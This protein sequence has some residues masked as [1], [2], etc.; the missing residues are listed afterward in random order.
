[1]PHARSTD[2]LQLGLSVG[3]NRDLDLGSSLIQ[4]V[5]QEVDAPSLE[6]HHGLSMPVPVH[7]GLEWEDDPAGN[8]NSHDGITV[9]R[10]MVS[11]G[12]NPKVHA[13]VKRPRDHVATV[14]NY[15][16][17]MERAAYV[18]AGE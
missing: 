13:I 6:Q 8:R 17:G 10:D 16:I 3:R 11:K 9:R 2:R 1:M 7:S 15:S 4:V 5:A 18:L 14:Q 12:V